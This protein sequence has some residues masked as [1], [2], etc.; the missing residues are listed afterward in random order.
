MDYIRDAY[1]VPAKIGGEVIY[2]G[3][4]LTQRGTITGAKG[5]HLMI[6]L[7]GETKPSKFHPTWELHYL[8][9]GAKP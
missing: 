5:A 2:T 8:E 9:K 1:Q 4:R 3:S 7:D 6:L